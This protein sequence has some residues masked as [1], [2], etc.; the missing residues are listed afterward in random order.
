MEGVDFEVEGGRIAFF[1][2][3]IILYERMHLQVH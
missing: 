2:E 3:H 1:F